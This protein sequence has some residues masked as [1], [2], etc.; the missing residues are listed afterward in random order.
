MAHEGRLD[1]ARRGATLDAQFLAPLTQA[2]REQLDSY[3]ANMPAP[4]AIRRACGSIGEE[5]VRTLVSEGV[6]PTTLF[7]VTMVPLIEVAWADGQ[8]QPAER[9]ALLSGSADHGLHPEQIQYQVAAAW[10]NEAP[11]PALFD[12]WVAY[13]SALDEHLFARERT[14]LMS[15]LVARAQDIARAAGG[16]LGIGSM[17]EKEQRVIEKLQDAF[18][19]PEQFAELWTPEREED[20]E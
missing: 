5:M 15:M 20:R 3:F 10:L 18:R 4:A 1:I 7:A 8:V 13:I 14:L 9:E 12:A 6:S 2:Q 17:N 19:Y 16:F 11:P